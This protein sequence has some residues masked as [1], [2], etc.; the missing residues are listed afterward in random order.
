[1][2]RVDDASSYLEEDPSA[3]T[4]ERRRQLKGYELY[5]VEQWACSRKDPT[6]VIVN[7]TGDPSHSVLVSVLS[8]PTDESVWS[9]R[10]RLYFAAASKYKG[11]RRETPL[12]ILMVTN[13]SWFPSA[14][15]VVLVPDGDVKKHREDLIVNEDL[16][17][18]GC[19]GRAGLSLGPPSDAT[20]TKFYQQYKI[21]DQIPLFGAVIELVKLCQV[22]LVLF[23]KLEPSYADGL[24]C[25]VTEQAINVWW[26][27]V[28]TDFFDF[29]PHDGVL[30]PT[31]VAAL[32][33]LLTGARNRL[34]AYGAPVTKDPF[35]LDNLKNGI[36][37]FQKSQ[38]LAQTRRLDRQT[39]HRLQRATAKAAQGEGW[40]VPR[41]VK[42]TMA[43]LSGK[44]GEMVMGRVAGREKAGIAD[45]ETL[46][47]ERFVQLVRGERC[48]W[49]WYGRPRRTAERGEVD[50]PAAVDGETASKLETGRD[51]PRR[52]MEG[53]GARAHLET[54]DQAEASADSPIGAGNEAFGDRES[55]LRRAVLRS[56]A[57]RKNEARSG[58]GKIK[59]AVGLSAIRG[60]HQQPQ[61]EDFAV[62]ERGRSPIK[63]WAVDGADSGKKRRLLPVFSDVSTDPDTERSTKPTPIRTTMEAFRRKREA[64]EARVGGLSHGKAMSRSWSI[65]TESRVSRAEPQHISGP[66]TRKGSEDSGKGGR[67]DE[68]PAHPCRD[69]GQQDAKAASLL[70]RRT[71]SLPRLEDPLGPRRNSNR[72]PRHLSFS[73]AEDI[74]LAWEDITEPSDEP[75]DDVVAAYT[76]ECCMAETAKRSYAHVLDMQNHMAYWVEQRLGNIESLELEA[77]QDRE[78][79]DTSYALCA[80]EYQTMTTRLGRLLPDQRATLMESV[81][82]VGVLG[83]KLDYELNNLVIKVEDVEDGVESIERHVY[84]LEL[85]AQEFA[86]D[87]GAEESWWMWLVRMVAGI[88]R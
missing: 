7:H 73:S 56:V 27:E 78:E 53:A 74:V 44:G 59:D 65:P 3:T 79:M 51:T 29:E 72:W 26:T 67:S 81:R 6:F 38:K 86:E 4:V 11:R 47:L 54:T 64:E 22:A 77:D 80:K 30:G 40:T 5:L 25:D 58:L 69:G 49:L 48:R 75:I 82:N 32:I 34:H 13:L 21:S 43:E 16:K 31:T 10:L 8:I 1:M 42:S 18:L 55:Q 83:A 17:R 66:S 68:E 39:L 85:K 9:P 84:S 50:R 41:A 20:R 23:D 61:K 70:L 45:V 63:S 33:G 88:G 71:A 12:G 76:R 24:L 35:D 14:L 15:T 46:D 52:S 60:R 36:A 28:G 2:S 87:D 37:H 19:S 62:V 57:S